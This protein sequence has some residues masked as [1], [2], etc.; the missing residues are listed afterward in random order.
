MVPSFGLLLRDKVMRYPVR[1][2]REIGK[3]GNHRKQRFG[4]VSPRITEKAQ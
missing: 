1:H 3:P 4:L 2:H